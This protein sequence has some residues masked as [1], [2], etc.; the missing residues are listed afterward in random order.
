VVALPALVGIGIAWRPLAGQ[1][2]LVR[3]LR[4]TGLAFAMQ[5]VIGALDPGRHGSTCR[6]TTG[7]RSTRDR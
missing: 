4:T 6:A 2:G 5:E 1:L 3:G 7:P